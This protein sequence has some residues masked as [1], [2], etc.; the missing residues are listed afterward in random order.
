MREG[1]RKKIA[2]EKKK[3]YHKRERVKADARER[4]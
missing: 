1:E 3:R 2:R 4:K